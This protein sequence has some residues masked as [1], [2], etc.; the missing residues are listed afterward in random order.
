MSVTNKVVPGHR[1]G[2]LLERQRGPHLNQLGGWIGDAPSLHFS[3]GPGLG[4]LSAPV[5]NLLH[6]KLTERQGGDWRHSICLGLAVLLP[7][8]KQAIDPHLRNLNHGGGGGN[9]IA[10]RSDGN[11][12]GLGKRTKAASQNKCR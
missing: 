12:D 6:D 9:A 1:I 7:Q 5:T 2:A 8:K 11:G 3:R 10:G 4:I